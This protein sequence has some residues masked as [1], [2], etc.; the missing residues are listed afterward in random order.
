[1]KK[2]TVIL[3]FIILAALLKLSWSSVNKSTDLSSLTIND[4][5]LGDQFTQLPDALN[6]DNSLKIET[7]KDGKIVKLQTVNDHTN[8]S[9]YGTTITNNTESYKSILGNHFVNKIY[10]YSQ[11]MNELV[12]HDSENNINLEIVYLKTDKGNKINWVIMSR[13]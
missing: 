12:Y 3:I 11:G 9:A 4:L 8:I 6:S 7:D 13:T 5:S 1:M 10:D 2:T